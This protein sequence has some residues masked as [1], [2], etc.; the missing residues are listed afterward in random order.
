L[1]EN[2]KTVFQLN[3]SE[4]C[5]FKKKTSKKLLTIKWIFFGE[6][7]KSIKERENRELWN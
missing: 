4:L 6:I 1:E 5:Y 7:G 2:K 3:D